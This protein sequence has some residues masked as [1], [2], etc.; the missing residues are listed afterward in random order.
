NKIRCHHAKFVEGNYGFILRPGGDDERNK[1]QSPPWFVATKSATSVIL[2]Y[3]SG[4]VTMEEIVRG[5]LDFGISF[6]TVLEVDKAPHP[7]SGFHPRAFT[8]GLG[9][10]PNNFLP[11]SSD[12]EMYIA[13]RTKVLRS[14]FGRV[15]RE[16]GGIVAR[17]ASDIVPV[18]EVL[19]GPNYGDELVAYSDRAGEEKYYVGDFADPRSLNLISGVYH[20][21]SK[22]NNVLKHASFWPKASTWDVMGLSGDQWSP[23]AEEFYQSRL[24][25]LQAG[26]FIL[27]SHPEWKV[28]FKYNRAQTTKLI[29]GSER[30][31]NDFISHSSR[32]VRL[33]KVMPEVISS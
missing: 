22:N 2:V 17:I 21:N 19:D 13:D 27:H 14:S 15:A 24:V 1:Q 23:M 26:R 4:W 31:A 33:P 6:R 28:R 8:E 18:S 11:R 5:F 25:D 10:R 9:I 32:M 16:I 29:A 3:R 20:I 7:K 30:I 12:Y